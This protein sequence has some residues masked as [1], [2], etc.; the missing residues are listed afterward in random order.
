MANFFG[1][2][3]NTNAQATPR[4]ILQGKFNSARSSLLIVIA[5][6][7]INIALIFTESNTYFLF[8][9]FV[10]YLLA[11]NGALYTGRVPGFYVPAA[12]MWSDAAFYIALA[13]AAVCILLFVLCWI[14]S[15]KNKVGW[16]IA[17]LV[18]SIIDTALG[19]LYYGV[20]TDIIIDIVF[21]AWLIFSLISGISA[22]NKLKALP[23][24]E[25][26]IDTTAEAVEAAPEV[27]EA[28]PEAVEA[29]PEAAP[30]APVA[31]AEEAAE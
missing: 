4:A 13:V 5:F 21:H 18:F 11:V 23:E 6:T 12:Y 7:L 20:S 3:N 30:E 26:V 8:S 22:Y 15:K 14:F 28:A 2:S 10:P 17:A 16:L 27:I 9:L 25:E 31:A 1:N 19:L 24:E 29:A